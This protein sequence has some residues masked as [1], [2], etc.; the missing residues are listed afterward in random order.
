MDLGDVRKGG[1]DWIGLPQDK[2]KWKALVNAIMNLR[3][4]YI[5]SKLPSV[6]TTDGPSSSAQLYGVS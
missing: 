2:G 3:V 4:P 6:Y 1:V 5:S